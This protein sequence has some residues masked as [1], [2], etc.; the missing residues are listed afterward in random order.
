MPVTKS[1]FEGTLP[2]VAAAGGATAG[3][4]HFDVTRKVL[5]LPMSSATS[6]NSFVGLVQGLIRG[7]PVHTG[8]LVAGA[9]MV[10]AT[11]TSRLIPAT[12]STTNA[13]AAAA[14]AA[15]GTTGDFAL[16]LPII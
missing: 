12:G 8:A 11:G 10:W 13:Y 15:G 4:M 9:R 7:V 5:S 16:V 3:T 6:G 2:L 1:N 14:K